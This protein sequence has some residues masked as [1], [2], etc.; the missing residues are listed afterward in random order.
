MPPRLLLPGDRHT[1]V[2]DAINY[3]KT[4][5]AHANLGAISRDGSKT[6]QATISVRTEDVWHKW[7][8]IDAKGLV[9]GRMASRVALLLRGKHKADFTPHADSGDAVIIINARDVALTGN[10]RRAKA[11]HRHTGYPGGIKSTTAREILDGR[12]PERVI[13]SAIRGMMPDGPLA[14]KQLT[15]LRVYPGSE[16]LHDAQQPESLDLAALNAKNTIVRDPGF[17]ANPSNTSKLLEDI[18]GHLKPEFNSVKAD[19]S[20][21]S[22]ET[23]TLTTKLDRV[24]DSVEHQART[25]NEFMTRSNAEFDSND[26]FRREFSEYKASTDQELRDIRTNTAKTNELL[27]AL[28]EKL[29]PSA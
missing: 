26:R 16:H 15:R 14:T 22:D 7:H 8:V 4:F 23:R 13:E 24:S 21:L 10:K 12:F 25:L 19:V 28:I 1:Y 20:A 17:M 18:K 27:S 9:L 2:D 5:M 29:T 6:R 11:Y 3:S